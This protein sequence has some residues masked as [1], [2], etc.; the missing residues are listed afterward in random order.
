MPPFATFNTQH[1]P[2]IEVKFGARPESDEEFDQYLQDLRSLYSRKEPFCIYF[3]ASDMGGLPLKYVWRQLDFMKENETMT[4]LF[5]QKAAIVVTNDI[6]RGFVDL[7]FRF[8]PV[9][10]PIRLFS[11][12]VEAWRWTISPST[13]GAWM[14]KHDYVVK[15]LT[16][17]CE[18]TNAEHAARVRHKLD[19]MA[20]ENFVDSK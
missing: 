13:A 16:A 20:L 10:A 18:D 9:A 7:L 4:I 17:I 15:K 11:D 12:N 6:V 1:W 2:Y 14:P 19:E 8:K 3:D 5:M